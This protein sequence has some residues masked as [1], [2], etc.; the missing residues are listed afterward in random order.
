MANIFTRVEGL[1]FLAACVMAAA[2][3]PPIPADL[4]TPVQQRIAINGP[5]GEFE[6]R[7]LTTVDFASAMLIYFTSLYSY[8]N[9]LEYIRTAKPAVRAIWHFQRQPHFPDVLGFVRNISN[10]KDIF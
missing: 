4:T 5:N 8:I 9:W 3:Y 6:P 7:A 10:L 1:P 2:S